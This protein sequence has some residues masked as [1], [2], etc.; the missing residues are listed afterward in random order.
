[1]A[2]MGLYWRP[3]IEMTVAPD[4]EQRANDLAKML[5]NSGIEMKA[6]EVAQNSEGEPASASR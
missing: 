3:V 2:G 1:M 6:T 5:R 4:G